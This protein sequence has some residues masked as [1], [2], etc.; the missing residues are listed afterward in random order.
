MHT[1]FLCCKISPIEI[2]FLVLILGP[3]FVLTITASI[4]EHLKKK[5]KKQEEQYHKATHVKTVTL[6]DLMMFGTIEAEYDDETSILTAEQAA[7]PKFGNQAPNR[8]EVEGYQDEDKE[9]V[10]RLLG[11]AYDKKDEILTKMAEQVLKEMQYDRPDDL[12]EL[13]AVVEQIAVTDFQFT[14]GEELMT[15]LI[16][17]G[18]EIGT[19]AYSLTALYYSSPVHWAYEATKMPGSV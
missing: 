11:K 1:E 17:A 12:P 19:D 16:N 3:V 5:R 7:L 10:M 2:A 6:T 15:M 14:S 13:A 4:R 18:A 9:T 8:I